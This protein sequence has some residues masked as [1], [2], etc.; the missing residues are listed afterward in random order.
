MRFSIPTALGH[1]LGPLLLEPSHNMMAFSYLAVAAA[2]V[3]WHNITR[4]DPH[5]PALQATRHAHSSA[6]CHQRP[7]SSQP[8]TSLPPP[9]TRDPRP[10]TRS[11]RPPL[12]PQ[13]C[14]ATRPDD[15]SLPFPTLPLP[16]P[17]PPKTPPHHH[18]QHHHNFT[19]PRRF[20]TQYSTTTTTVPH[21]RSLLSS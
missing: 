10:A 2:P 19:P 17:L 6:T 3:R 12:H 1:Y 7:S 4:L 9:E 8:Q 11:V 14:H 21:H 18:Y 15:G 16:T 13:L 20:L 5:S